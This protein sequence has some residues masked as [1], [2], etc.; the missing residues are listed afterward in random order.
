MIDYPSFFQR[1][2][3]D[4]RQQQRYR[5]FQN[6]ERI[7]GRALM[8]LRAWNAAP[9]PNPKK[10]RYGAPMIIWA[11]GSTLRW[12]RPC[13]RRRQRL[14]REPVV[15]EISVVPTAPSSNSNRNWPICTKKKQHWCSHRAMYQTMRP[16]LPLPDCCRIA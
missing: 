10:S 16:S 6:I 15:P 11:W 5:V 13:R 9:R 1:E 12:S 2:L 14:V 3:D 8:G 7:A 4:I